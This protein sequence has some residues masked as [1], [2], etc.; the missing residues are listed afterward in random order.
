MGG[1]SSHETE[2][3][4]QSKAIDKRLMEESRE[5]PGAL[6]CLLLGPGESGKSTVFKQMRLSN[7]KPFTPKER[8]APNRHSDA[9][10]CLAQRGRADACPKPL[11]QMSILQMC[12]IISSN[13]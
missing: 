6:R 3:D 2:E 4:K 7:R 1:C 10:R 5:D 8:G 12:M 9:A 11:L 13:T